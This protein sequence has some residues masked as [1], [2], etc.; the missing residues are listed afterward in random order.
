V[1]YRVGGIPEWLEDGKVGLLAEPADPHDL[2]SKLR[3]LLDDPGRARAM[4]AAGRD[5]VRKY[6]LARHVEKTLAA[7]GEVRARFEARFRK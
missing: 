6:S 2:A 4:G 3:T 5:A 1:A 7:Y